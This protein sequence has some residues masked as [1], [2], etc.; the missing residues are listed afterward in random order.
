MT[1]AAS[2][3]ITAD[4]ISELLDTHWA[5]WTLQAPA[6]LVP[7]PATCAT[8]SA[9]PTRAR[10]TASLRSKPDCPTPTPELAAMPGWSRRG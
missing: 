2:Y 7:L 9:R 6:A 1:V 4:Q 5:E 3:A 8:G 10:P